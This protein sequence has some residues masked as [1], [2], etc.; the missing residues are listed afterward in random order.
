MVNIWQLIPKVVWWNIWLTRNN[1]LFNNIS[2]TPQSVAQKIK[3]HFAEMVGKMKSPST[4]PTEIANWLGSIPAQV[5]KVDCIQPTCPSPWRIRKSGD[6]FNS[7]WIN[8]PSA[9]I[10]FDDAS[11]G[12]LDISGARGLVY[13]LDK[14]LKTDLVGALASCPTI[15]LKTMLFSNLSR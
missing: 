7:W 3:C 5:P 12:N 15:R 2:V 10:F 14:L 13:A 4:L 6:E 1:F 8:S 11:K 9:S